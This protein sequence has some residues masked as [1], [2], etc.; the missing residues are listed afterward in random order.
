QWMITGRSIDSLAA[1]LFGLALMLQLLNPIFALLC[2]LFANTTVPWLPRFWTSSHYFL[3][4]LGLIHLLSWVALLKAARILPKIWK[5]RPAS[6]AVLSWRER[7]L[8][9][10][11]GTSQIRRQFR[12]AL[13]RVNPFF[14]LIGRDR[15]KPHY[16]WLFVLAMA[17][18][19]LW[20]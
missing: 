15:L 20:R 11:Q 18:V 6:M 3:L 12:I 16:A 8:R 9:F 2:I 13:L 17:G 5:D 14:W 10:S 1:A 7:W 19:W 4:S